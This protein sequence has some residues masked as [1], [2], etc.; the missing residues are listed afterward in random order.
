M[1]Q[2]LNILLMGERLRA[3]R[4]S[5]KQTMKEFAELCGISERYLADIE[6][7]VKAPKLETFVRIVNAAG[8]SPEYLL[9][10]SLT[11]V[12]KGNLVRDTLNILPPEQQALFQD[13]ILGLVKSMGQGVWLSPH[14]FRFIF[15]STSFCASDRTRGGDIF[16]HFFGSSKVRP[17]QPLSPVRRTCSGWEAH[18]TVSCRARAALWV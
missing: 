18:N 13:F 14:R 12:D 8:V 3:F 16:S 4:V 5:K 11:K 6:R 10:D 9:Q 2:P 7:G 1:E 15:S 17:P